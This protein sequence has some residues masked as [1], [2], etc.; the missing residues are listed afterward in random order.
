[1]AQGELEKE[2]VLPQG[3][4]SSILL[5]KNYPCSMGKGM[6][7]VH[8]R[9]YFA[10]DKIRNKELK[11]VCCPTEELTADCNSKPLQGKLF[12]RHR[13][14]TMGT[15]EEDFAEHKEMHIRILK[16]HDLCVDEEDLM[17]T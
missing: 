2:D 10:A 8:V 11:T 12:H 15:K 5:Q 14:T 13:N 16:Q 7:H 1:M 4:K 9:F 3:N 6:K 17:D